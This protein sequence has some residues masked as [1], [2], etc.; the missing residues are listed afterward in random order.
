MLLSRLSRF[1]FPMLG[2]GCALPLIAG[3][4]PQTLLPSYREQPIVGGQKAAEGFL[5]AVGALV[6]YHPQIGV[7][8]FCSGTLVSDRLI[9]S[10]A[11]CVE[12]IGNPER[13][14]EGIPVGFYTGVSVEDADAMSRVLPIKGNDGSGKNDWQAHP[15]YYGGNPPGDLANYYDISVLKLQSPTTITPMKMIRPKEVGPLFAYGAKLLIAGYGVTTANT[16]TSGVKRYGTTHLAAI[17]KSEILIESGARKCSGDSGG[18][19]LIE[20]KEGNGDYRHIGVASR[21]DLECSVGSIETRVDVYLDWIASFGTIPCGSGASADCETLPPPKKV[22][23]TCAK[24]TDCASKLCVS[25]LGKLLCSQACTLGGNDCPTGYAC[26][27]VAGQTGAACVKQQPVTP[28]KKKGLGEECSANTDCESNLC[29]QTEES[30]IC[31]KQC[32]PESGCDVDGLECRDDGD[33]Q[34]LCLPVQPETDS[35]GGGC[36]MSAP[37]P[38]AST[39]QGSV[40]LPLILA[41]GLPLCRRRRAARPSAERG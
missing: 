1:L 28:P 15:K 12:A 11:H 35:S 29:R 37:S 7:K 25:Q 10:A 3:C 4:S 19:T 13:I 17:G 20:T 27:A 6:A 40:L 5:P 26:S 31:S 9:V 33:G 16:D 23:E 22:G 39:E 41:L 8:A 18:P 24:A 38:C 34:N 14:P 2:V 36:A 21:A 30:Q 32:D